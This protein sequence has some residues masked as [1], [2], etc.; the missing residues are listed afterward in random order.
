MCYETPKV[1]N[2]LKAPI[3]GAQLPDELSMKKVSKI[4]RIFPPDIGI[5]I[6]SYQTGASLYL[7]AHDLEKANTALGN[8]VRSHR[9]HL[10]LDVDYPGICSRL[11]DGVTA[12]GSD[13]QQFFIKVA[14]VMARPEG[15]TAAGFE[16]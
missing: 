2:P 4:S 13:Y 16:T 10:L 7:T 14:K 3:M 9:I 12:K 11:C 6:D 15:Q 8:I 1:N 5:R